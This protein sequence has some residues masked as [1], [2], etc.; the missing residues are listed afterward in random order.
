MPLTPS[1]GLAQVRTLLALHAAGSLP[2]EP[3]EATAAAALKRFDE[4]TSSLR[5]LLTETP[6]RTAV[7]KLQEKAFDEGVEAL[8]GQLVKMT[9]HPQSSGVFNLYA[10]VRRQ[11]ELR[12]AGL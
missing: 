10:E 1:E 7:L 2:G 5:D 11:R 3:S 4:L 12:L 6:D 8:E 9:F